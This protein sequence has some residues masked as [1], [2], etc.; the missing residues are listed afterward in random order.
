[1]GWTASDRREC[2]HGGFECHVRDRRIVIVITRDKNG[3]GTRAKER[4]VCM[5]GG[6]DKRYNDMEQRLQRAMVS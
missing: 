3:D 1:M 6:D 2:I 4:P 5:G